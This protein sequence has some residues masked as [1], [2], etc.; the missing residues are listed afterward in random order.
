MMKTIVV[1]GLIGSGKS[2]ASRILEKHGI[3]VYDSDSRVKA[4]YEIHPELK[5]MLSADIFS[6]PEKL[7]ELEN[8]VY[9]VLLEDFENWKAEMQGKGHIAVGFESAILL[10]KTAFDDFGDFVILID[11]PEELR[12]QRAISRG[13]VSEESVLKRNKMQKD[14][15]ENPRV[16]AII[17]NDGTAEQL[18]NKLIEIIE[19]INYNGK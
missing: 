13:T 5:A 9:P 4:L 19:T 14:Q 6:R 15:K 2:L 10:E 18:E 12:L 11:A 16:N 7:A 3:P 1:T 8:A 17:C